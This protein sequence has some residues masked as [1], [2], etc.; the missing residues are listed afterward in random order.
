MDV[1]HICRTEP[2][3]TVTELIHEVS[4]PDA[5]TLDLYR[6]DVDWNQVVDAIFNAHK[7]ISWW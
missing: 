5:E 4:G 6:E 1:L 3:E 2:D 7:V